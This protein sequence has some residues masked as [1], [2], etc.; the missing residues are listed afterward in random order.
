MQITFNIPTNYTFEHFFKL[1]VKNFVENF[2][3]T[4]WNFNKFVAFIDKFRLEVEHRVVMH[5]GGATPVHKIRKCAP[6]TGAFAVQLVL[7]NT[8]PGITILKNAPR[9]DYFLC[10]LLRKTITISYFTHLHSLSKQL[11]VV[12]NVH[13]RKKMIFFINTIENA[14]ILKIF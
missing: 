12:T 13:T 3:N 14:P 2:V 11:R 9:I 1:S 10:S 4:F 7:K 6:C 8:P 5:L